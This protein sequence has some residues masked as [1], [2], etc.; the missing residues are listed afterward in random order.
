MHSTASPIVALSP[1]TSFAIICGRRVSAALFALSAVTIFVLALQHQPAPYRYNSVML[2]LAPPPAPGIAAAQSEFSFAQSPFPGANPLI[3]RWQPFIAE[4]SERFA[5]PESWIAAAM[6][7]ES[8]GRTMLGGAP[9]TSKAGAAGLMQLM[10]DTYGELRQRYR[11]GADVHNPRDN[12]LAG[13]AY[14][15]ELREKYGYPN[16]FAAYNAGPGRLDEHLQKGK[17]LP[18]ETR[19]YLGLVVGLIDFTGTAAAKPTQA[20]AAQGGLLLRR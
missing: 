17:S 1:S 10:G 2:R 14:L 20:S 9:I 16:L 4:A 11:L 13:T 6:R 8:G 12:I 15:Q 5:I 7:V 3:G 18:A 19:N